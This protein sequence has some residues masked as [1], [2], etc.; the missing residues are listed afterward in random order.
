MP[1]RGRTSS[2]AGSRPRER[3]GSGRRA[4]PTSGS[5]PGT[6]PGEAHARRPDRAIGSPAP[7]RELLECG[8]LVR[9]DRPITVPVAVGR[10]PDAEREA[11]DRD[12]RLERAAVGEQHSSE[13]QPR[14]KE[15]IDDLPSTGLVLA[16]RCPAD[17]APRPV[18]A[19][20]ERAHDRMTR[21]LEMAGR[22]PVRAGITAPGP[23]AR[24]ALAEVHPRSADDRA[25]LA[26]DRAGADVGD[27]I[28]MRAGCLH[29]GTVHRVRPRRR[30]SRYAPRSCQSPDCA[31]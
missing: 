28:H 24:A 9:I 26:L 20:L 16:E 18:V 3:A 29:R 14:L 8:G 6:S 25:R 30:R 1:R 5:S 17:E 11:V 23:P 31:P 27:Q 7:A 19:L 4:R 21:L 10:L 13:V 2:R 22:V 15:R 12:A